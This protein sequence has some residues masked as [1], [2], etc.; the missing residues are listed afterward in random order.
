M[1]VI[2]RLAAWLVLHTESNIYVLVLRTLLKSFRLILIVL[3]LTTFIL[4]L[5]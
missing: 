2:K 4:Q 3:F 1:L 5:K